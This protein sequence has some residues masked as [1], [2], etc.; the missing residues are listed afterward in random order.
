M[1]SKEITVPAKQKFNQVGDG[2]LKLKLLENSSA[3]LGMKYIQEVV[4]ISI[5]IVTPMP[6]MPSCVLGLINWRNRI[7]WLIDLPKILGLH[8]IDINQRQYNVVIINVDS[9]VF[10]FAV[11]GI[12][13]TTKLPSDAIKSHE[14]EITSNLAPFLKGYAYQQKETLWVLD[15][16]AIVKS[17]ILYSHHS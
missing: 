12:E 9:I 4:L 16:A 10:G 15:V 8:P 3:L 6:N 14:E 1:N 17:S 7:L 11:Y 5:D 13:G 2:Y